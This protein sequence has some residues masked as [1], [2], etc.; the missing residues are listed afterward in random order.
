MADMVRFQPADV[1][2]IV[3]EILVSNNQKIANGQ[4]LFKLA[5][6]SCDGHGPG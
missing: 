6:C 3:L 1:S 5:P 4:V 2:E